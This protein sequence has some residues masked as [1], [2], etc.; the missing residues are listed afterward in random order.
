LI[1]YEKKVILAYSGIVV[2]IS[3]IIYI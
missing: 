2:I 3:W 1:T